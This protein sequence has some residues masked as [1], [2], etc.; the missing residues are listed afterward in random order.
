MFLCPHKFLGGPGTP[1]VLVVR[2]ELLTNR[3]PVVPGG[4]TVT[5]ANPVAPLPRRAGAPGGGRHARD[6]RVDQCRPG[7][8]AKAAVGTDVIHARTSPSC[9]GS[10][11]PGDEP[12]IELLGDL[13][14]ERLPIVSLRGPDAGGGY[15]HHN[16]VV[17][18]LNDLFGI[19]ARGGC[20]CA[21]PYGHRL[22]GSTSSSGTSSSARSPVVAG[23]QARLGPGQLQL[24]P[25]RRR[26]RL[27]GGGG[28]MAARRG[29]R[30]LGDYSFDPA[31][32]CGTTAPGR[33]AAAALQT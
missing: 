26:L 30:L 24:L 22:L 25:L 9:A 23:H 2:R 12:A 17:A 33:L 29:L 4:G 15:L 16:F 31:E 19:Q 21:G 18:L 6:R 14:A 1:G 11:R 10:W 20:S 8:P 3:V 13:D 5:F 32:G 27:P 7:V 28:R